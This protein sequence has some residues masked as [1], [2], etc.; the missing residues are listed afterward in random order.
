MMR[1]SCFFPK[2]G[3]QCCSKAS[4]VAAYCQRCTTLAVDGGG[5]DV[6]AEK[7]YGYPPGN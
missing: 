2:I 3:S 1:Q 4:D 5:W 6:V 7:T